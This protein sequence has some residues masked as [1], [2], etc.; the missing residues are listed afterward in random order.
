MNDI[1]KTQEKRHYKHNL[2]T[3]SLTDKKKKTT[4]KKKPNTLE[5]NGQ[6]GTIN[7]EN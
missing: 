1:S 5:Y 6:I 4:K 3:A 7:L 2:L